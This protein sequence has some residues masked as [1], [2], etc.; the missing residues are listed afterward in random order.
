MSLY[1]TYVD[2]VGDGVTTDFPVPFTY[3]D[4]NDV[5]VTVGGVVQSNTAYSYTNPNTIRITTA[6]PSLI[7][8]RIS[9]STAISAARVVFS[10]GSS[11]TGKQLNTAVTQLLYALQESIDRATA[12]IGLA[13]GAIGWDMQGKRIVNLANPVDPTDGTNKAYVD[14]AVKVPGPVGPIGP[15]GPKG[16]Q[17]IQ[18]IQG[19]LGPTGPQ[20]LKGD[21]GIQGPQGV[22]GSQGI[23]GLEG[24]VGPLGPQGN[25]FVPDVV[26]NNALRVNYDDETPGFSFLAIDLGAISFKNSATLADWSDWIPFGRGPTGPVGPQGPRGQQGVEGPQGIQGVQGVAGPVGLTFRG[27]YDVG[28]AYTPR[29]AVYDQGCMWVNISSSQGEA[30]PTLP[31]LNNARWTVATLGYNGTAAGIPF[32]P[33]GNIASATVQAA[34]AEVDAEKAKLVHTHLA[35]DITDLGTALTGNVK[36]DGVQSLTAGQKTQALSNIGAQPAGSYQVT[37]GYTPVNKAGDSMT[38]ALITTGNLTGYDVRANRTATTGYFYFGTG[39]NYIGFDGTN[40]TSTNWLISPNGNRYA[41][42]NELAAISNFGGVRGAYAGDYT[43]P[44]NVLCE[45]GNAWITGITSPVEGYSVYR[46]RYVQY[47]IN[48]GWYTAGWVS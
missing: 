22:Q 37:L 28:A 24:P 2:Y 1:N 34:I 41:A 19:N 45:I 3:I 21:T 11:T 26:G 6:P 35:A 17:G 13:A 5:V 32:A 39:G 27:G 43:D 29:D 8:V 31:T 38:G 40:F 46:Y 30:P 18:G 33:T 47:A 10:N 42:Y 16:D 48:G 15:E 14:E 23:Q 9:R 12:T 25:S 7:G 36:Y 20:G 4:V 44:Y